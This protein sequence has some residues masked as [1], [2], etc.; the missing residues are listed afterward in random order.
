VIRKEIPA[1]VQEALKEL[2]RRTTGV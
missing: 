2:Y 1:S